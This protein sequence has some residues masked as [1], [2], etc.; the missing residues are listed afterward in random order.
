MS[1]DP[2]GACKARGPGGY[3]PYNPRYIYRQWT[4]VDYSRRTFTPPRDR[5]KDE[6]TREQTMRS[7]LANAKR[8]RTVTEMTGGT[9]DNGI[10]KIKQEMHTLFGRR[11]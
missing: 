2:H 9:R 3:K 5:S 11:K 7:H 4:P 1:L 10:R 6:I 8:Q